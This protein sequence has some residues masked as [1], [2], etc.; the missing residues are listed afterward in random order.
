VGDAA[1]S[2]D[3]RS[4]V[5]RLP[6]ATLI[7]ALAD[8]RVRAANEVAAQLIGLPRSALLGLRPAE[9]WAGTDGRRAELAMSAPTDGTIDGYRAHRRLRSRTGTVSV[10]VW[11]RQIHVGGESFAAAIMVPETEPRAAV[12]SLAADWGSK[13]ADPTTDVG[14]LEEQ[15]D[16]HP[17]TVPQPGGQSEPAGDQLRSLIHPDDVDLLARSIRD[18][19]D[20]TEVRVR[21]RRA[22]GWE[23]TRCLLFALPNDGS[24]GVALVLGEASEA[25]SSA[26]QRIAVLERHLLQFAAELHAGGWGDAHSPSVDVSRLAA[27]DQLPRRQREVVDRLV[28]GERIPSIA[29]SMV[30]SA[31]TVRNHLTHVFAAFGVH[32]QSEL[33]ALLR[34]DDKRD[35]PDPPT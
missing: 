6:F 5:D 22:T 7:V 28:R 25:G 9:L 21:L 18:G 8:Q 11:V 17:S 16:A 19:A 31:S 35:L 3:L 34:R 13:S 33:L 14:N 30:L 2:A 32:S 1:G 29:A 23:S 24:S 10:M 4:F 26:G 20:G 27:L 12:R 15:I